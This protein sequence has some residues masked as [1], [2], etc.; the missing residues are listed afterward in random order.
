MLLLMVARTA[1]TMSRP[2]FCG[3]FS[4]QQACAAYRESTQECFLVYRT[5]HLC[6][7]PIISACADAPTQLTCAAEST[8]AT[9]ICHTCISRPLI[10][11]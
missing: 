10:Q 6:C 3:Q 2:S 9:D 5:I 1:A 4:D 11:R 8:R 7:G